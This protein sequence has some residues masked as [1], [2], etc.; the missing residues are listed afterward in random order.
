MELLGNKELL[1]EPKTAFLCSRK[2]SA[3]AILKC[4][5]W[6]IE[7][8]KSGTCVIGG[9]HSKI[10]KDVL[11]FLLKG[12]QPVIIVLARCMYK[13]WDIQIKD[14]LDSGNLLIVSLSP[15]Y[16][17]RAN[18]KSCAIRNKYIISIADKIVV[19]YLSPIGSLRNLVEKT[20][21]S[22]ICLN[23]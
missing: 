17:K 15:E 21:K 20:D 11:H 6:A 18:E 9:F 12:E 4:Y 3:S 8:R 5:D 22:I 16:Q 7:Q 13:R 19:G 10:E 1:K 14:R 23:E 2:V